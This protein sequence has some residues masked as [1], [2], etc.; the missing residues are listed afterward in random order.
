MQAMKSCMK[1]MVES[2]QTEGDLCKAAGNHSP[3]S[4]FM[5]GEY[6]LSFWERDTLL[7]HFDVAII[8]S[9]IV[10]LNA[11]LHLKESRPHLRILVLERGLMPFGA[12]SRNAGFACF[13]SPSEILDD[14]QNHSL[15]DVA[16][17]I[18]KRRNGLERLLSRTGKDLIDYDPCGSYDVFTPDDKAWFETC[19]DNLSR[20]NT[21]LEEITGERDVFTV[22]DESISTFGLGNTSHMIKNK[23]EGSIHTGKMMDALLGKASTSGIRIMNGMEVK[24]ILEHANNAVLHTEEGIRIHCDY[25]LIA[26][27]GF[28]RQF[29]PFEDI[30]PARAQVMITHPIENL[31][32]RGTFHHDRGFYYFRNVGNRI[33]LGGGRNLD[34]KGE[35][36]TELRTTPLIQNKLDELMKTMILPESSYTVD[37]RWSGIMGIGSQKKTI[38]KKISSRVFCS[39]RMG[40]MGVALGALAG[41]EGARMILEA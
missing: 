1:P 40:G 10:G 8:G 18:S 15:D 38:T 41:E 13:G 17:L 23:L 30:Q 2:A 34:F 33:L 31:K 39:V 16:A 35:T 25:V 11:A 6:P 4:A 26:T 12:S 7:G 20:L 37:M 27:N 9:G 28:A 5:S 29:L 24:Q 14:L 22:E 36:T 32:V 19:K 21:L 3:L